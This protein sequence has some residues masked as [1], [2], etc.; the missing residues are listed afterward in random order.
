MSKSSAGNLLRQKC[1]EITDLQ[2]L[3][4]NTIAR[5]S[6]EGHF[7]KGGGK[8]RNRAHSRHTMRHIS[9]SNMYPVSKHLQQIHS[10]SIAN[11]YVCACILSIWSAYDRAIGREAT[12]CGANAYE[13]T[14]T[15]PPDPAH[16][17]DP[18]LSAL[19]QHTEANRA[20]E[21]S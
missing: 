16:A 19:R 13:P 17:L 12:C 6:V 1:K 10:K 8:S 2:I 18:R 15:K 7:R 9:C 21:R 3:H 20:S 4:Y 14:P 5:N 11:L